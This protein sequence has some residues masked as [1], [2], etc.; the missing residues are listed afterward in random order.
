MHMLTN[1][2]DGLVV[3]QWYRSWGVY[4]EKSGLPAVEGLRQR[5]FAEE[6]RDELLATGVDF[7]ADVK[8]VRAAN[9]Q[10]K[11]VYYEW[12]ERARAK[13][14]DRT[15]GEY[16]GTDI[17]YGTFVPSAKWAAA[18][19]AAIAAKDGTTLER[20]IHDGNKAVREPA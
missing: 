18:Y 9:E 3:Q 14:F 4:H 2:K 13:V 19:R 8:A 16:Y 20:L 11:P 5:R 6:A 1:V 12:R 15:T 17:S 7:T 10:W